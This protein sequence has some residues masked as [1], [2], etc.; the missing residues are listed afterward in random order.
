MC[1]SIVLIGNDGL[2]RITMNKKLEGVGGSEN[3]ERKYLPPPL[4]NS[5]G[6]TETGSGFS[7]LQGNASLRTGFNGGLGGFR[8]LC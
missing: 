4:H 7:T 1:S 2:L 3:V 6:A 8:E 5:S